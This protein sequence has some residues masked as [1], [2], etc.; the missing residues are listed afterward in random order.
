VT[1][2]IEDP[3]GGRDR[4]PGAL[5]RAWGT[6][7]TRPRT[8]F[9]SAVAPADQAPGLIFASTVVLVEEATRL[10]LVADAYPVVGGQP[11]ASALLWL[12]V[13]VVLVAPALLH[14]TAALQTVI[15]IAFV[16]ERAGV[17]ETV[18]V[19]AYSTAPCALAGV[20]EP[21]VRVAATAYGAVLLA[22]GVSEVHDVS[23]VEGGL[24]A[25]LPAALVFGYAFRGFGALERLLEEIWR[26]IV[27]PLV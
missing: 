13:A 10:L 9:R 18:Q 15:L 22:V 21:A 17:S 2:W 23:L 16:E 25:S 5:L 1:Q 11:L 24:L 12:A 27:L 6:A 7:L 20:P 14:L 26:G 4:G 3:T 8:L 19:L